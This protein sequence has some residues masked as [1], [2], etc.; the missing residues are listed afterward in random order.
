MTQASQ[1]SHM[2]ET[3]ED[4]QMFAAAATTTIDDLRVVLAEETDHLKAARFKDAVA[5]SDR[6]AG[7][8]D[9]YTHYMATIEASGARLRE[10]AP[11]TAERLVASHDRL[12]ETAARNLPT[13]ERAR[14][15]TLRIV[16]GVNAL[17][18][19]NR[20][21]PTVYDPNALEETKQPGRA[22]PISLDT[23]I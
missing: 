8:A 16:K 14:D 7:L 15:T 9:S 6:K 10:L 2:I 1:A 12:A 19:K 11:E 3:A 17:I 20:V 23:A 18:E 21:G 5:L 22:A 4:A 13:V